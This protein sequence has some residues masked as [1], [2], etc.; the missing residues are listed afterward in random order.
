MSL[1]CRN[2]T[3]EFLLLSRDLFVALAL[4]LSSTFGVQ[5]R[6]RERLLS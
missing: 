2:Y 4:S 6:E 1:L 5:E 3:E